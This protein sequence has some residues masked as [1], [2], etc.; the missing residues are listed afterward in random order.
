MSAE[1]A[2]NVFKQELEDAVK[3]AHDAVDEVV[4]KF[5]NYTAKGGTDM[6]V[7]PVVE[8]PTPADTKT[9]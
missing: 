7:A 3:A 1:T 8:T 9:V 4:R 6:P 5:E 2:L